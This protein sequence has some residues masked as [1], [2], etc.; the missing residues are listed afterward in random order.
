VKFLFI[1]KANS[2]SY[3]DKLHDFFWKKKNGNYEFNSLVRKKILKMINIFC[4]S[5]DVKTF[6]KDIQ[7]TG[8]LA[9]YNYTKYSDLDIH[10]LLDFNEI[11]DDY[12]LIKAR[13]ELECWK[14][15]EEH[16]VAINDFEVQVYFQ[17]V[18]E[19]HEASGLFSLGKSKWI[20][21]PKHNPPEIDEKDLSKK[22]KRFEDIIDDF[23]DKLG[24]SKSIKEF[25]K[26]HCCSSKLLDKIKKTR[27]DSLYIDG[28]FGIGNLVFK[29][30]RNSEHIKELKQIIIDSYDS[31]FSIKK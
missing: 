28:E 11:S 2:F 3:N 7:L 23:E 9:N 4:E 10:I 14:W 26:I 8:S 12:D 27:K 21:R 19:P 30:L 17:D 25:K 6:I 13:L 18:N 1:K 15:N 24:K 16:E 31:I 29:N 22:T 5:V 20:K